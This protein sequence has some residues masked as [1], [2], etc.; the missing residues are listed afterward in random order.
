MK[1]SRKRLLIS[2]IAMLLVAMLALGTATFAWFTQNTTATASG[3]SVRTSKTSSLLISDD[4]QE[5]ASSFTYQDV[6]P[7]MLPSSSIDGSHWF[8]TYATKSDNFGSGS[9]TISAIPNSPANKYVFVDQLNIK[10]DGD[11][12]VGEITITVGNWST[13]TTYLNMALVPVATK[14]TGGDTDMTADQ[15]RS[16]IYSDSA[17]GYYPVTA[18]GA[19]QAEPAEGAEDTRTKITPT[20]KTASSWTINVADLAANAEAHYNLFIWFEGQDEQ[21]YDNNAGQGIS[22]MTFTV[23]GT[24]VAETN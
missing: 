16:N 19:L 20:A 23:T 17:S 3:I 22:G 1:K 24:P 2:S 14:T 5:Y 21:C 7:V 9:N 4:T 10:N 6:Q 12:T 15:F 8:Y 18:A 11:V 13:S